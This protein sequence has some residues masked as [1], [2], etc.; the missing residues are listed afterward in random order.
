[1]IAQGYLGLWEF[2]VVAWI[3]AFATG[4]R[5]FTRARKDQRARRFLGLLLLGLSIAA[6]LYAIGVSLFREYVR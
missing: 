3:A 5:L 2:T 6:L 1:M 4:G